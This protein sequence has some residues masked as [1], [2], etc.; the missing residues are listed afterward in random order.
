[1]LL[2]SL[3][4]ANL[5]MILR[6]RQ[7]VMWAMGFP[8]MFVL[9]FGLFASDGQPTT[10]VAVV[11][12]ARDDVAVQLVEN[13][14]QI[15]TFI[16]TMDRDEAEAREALQEGELRYLL[17]I[18]A[19]FATTV[20]QAPPAT[21]R[22]VYDDSI[23][24]GGIVVNV[25]E[26]FLDRMNLDLAGAPSRL[27]LSPEGVVARDVSF[28]DFLLPGI[29]VW[30][31]MSF[32]V[33]GIATSM[34]SYREKKILRR[35]LATPLSARTFFL[36]Q[37]FAYLV[38]ALAQ[39][40]TILGLGALVFDVAIAGNILYIGFLVIVGNLVFLNLGFIVGAFSKNAQAASG[41]GNLLVLPLMLFSGIFFP[42]DSLP[43]FFGDLVGYLP[44]A[45]MVDAVRGVTLDGKPFWDYPGELTVMAVWIVGTTLIATKIFRFR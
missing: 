20:S 19:G 15:E 37:I 28:I 30:G 16:I 26:R 29:A 38:V 34:A 39:A 4:I 9:I 1:M 11:D 23:P 8:L 45:P 6:N 43:D 25:V 27:T 18:P 21:V 2:T 13:L 42:K 44:L 17:I 41:L 14:R 7:V 22:L 12:Y 33:I 3:A 40:A 24:T 5:K 32:S 35:I 31:V 36:A 10:T